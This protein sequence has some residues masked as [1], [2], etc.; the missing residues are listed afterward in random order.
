MGLSSHEVRLARSLFSKAVKLSSKSALAVLLNSIIIQIRVPGLSDVAHGL[1]R[2]KSSLKRYI[3]FLSQ[4]SVF[5]GGSPLRLIQ[6][7][8]G[9]RYRCTVTLSM[10]GRI[11]LRMT[12]E[13]ASKPRIS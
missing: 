7:Y 8:A 12:L 5:I 10:G 1:K 6:Q 3:R 11:V 2:R 9:I 13:R 4:L